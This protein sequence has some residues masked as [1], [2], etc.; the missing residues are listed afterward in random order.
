MGINFNDFAERYDNL[1]VADNEL[2]NLLIRE[3]RI[4]K[5]V[6]ILDFG[7]GTGNYIYEFQKLGFENIFG[8]DISEQMREKAIAKTHTT[9]YRNFNEVDKIFDF[10]F[11]IDVAH[12][13]GDINSLAKSLYP[14]CNN[15][16][17]I[18][19]VTQSHEQIKQRRYKDFF[20]TAIKMDLQR[21]HDIEILLRSF[22]DVGFSFQK[23]EVY[24]KDT[25][26]VLD[27]DFLNKVKNKCFSMF[28][29]IPEDE[30]N[31]GIKEFEN[32]LV[33]A[34][35]NVIKETYAGKTILIFQKQTRER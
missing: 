11:I 25:I 33:T 29:L 35:D 23:K 34:K 6:K 19:I 24:R 17:Q 5:N 8:L 12:L 30:F 13:I 28:E 26:R 22:K 27:I 10:I 32:A 9:I 1:R 2:I 15:G 21:Y 16:S 20:P 18:A 4:E 14:I 7:C 31:H 3:S